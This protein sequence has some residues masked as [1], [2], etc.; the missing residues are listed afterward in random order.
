[1]NFLRLSYGECLT[2]SPSTCSRGSHPQPR[3][4]ISQVL[5]WDSAGCSPPCSHTGPGWD[6]LSPHFHSSL[7]SPFLTACSWDVGRDPQFFQNLPNAYNISPCATV[8]DPRL[9]GS[10]TR[11]LSVAHKVLQGPTPSLSP[12]SCFHLCAKA[13]GAGQGR[14][15]CGNEHLGP[16][17]GGLCEAAQSS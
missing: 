16:R 4:Q 14:E 3:V 7:C 10:G 1:M 8:Q 2:F 13:Q 12:Q 17:T 11:P 9:R 6:L 5:A 15:S